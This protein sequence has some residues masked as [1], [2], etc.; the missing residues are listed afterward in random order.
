M[1]S[2]LNSQLFSQKCKSVFF[3]F[4]MHIAHV[5][6]YIGKDFGGPVAGLAAMTAGL[7]SLGRQ[8]EVYAAHRPCEGE[9]VTLAPG[10]KGN[11]CQDV[12]LGILRH[13]ALLWKLL[14]GADC[15]LIHS[16]GLWGDPNRCAA[17]VARRKKIPHLLGTSGMLEPNALRRARWK[18]L[19]VRNL[20]Q[21]RALW[22]AD[23][24]L[25]NSEKEY[26]DIRAY[27]LTNPVALIP[28]PVFGPESVTNPVTTR[29]VRGRL[30]VG[31]RRTL[32]YL[33]RIHPVKGVHR[34]AEAWCR[35]PEFHDCWNLIIAGPD[36]GGFQATIEEILR[37]GGCA[38]SVTFTGSLDD[39]WKW[40]VLRQADLFVMPSDY[41]NFG[42]AIVEALLAG[43]PV[44]ATTRTPWGILRDRQAGW[45]VEP[46]TDALTTVLREALAT[47]GDMLLEMGVRGEAIGGNFAPDVI[48]LQLVEV[49]DWLLGRGDRPGSVRG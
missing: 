14:Q 44:I 46:E 33:G 17:T 32:L 13:S 45:V 35:I 40:G 24:L 7:A 16:H 15:S 6:Q 23:C 41:E 19:I 5:I 9:M 18:K 38:T 3:G 39:R 4:I 29:E 34:L 43:V 10:I 31:R 25:A 21:D 37:K 2:L 30:P 1:L 28:N 20:F 42:I 48:A 49:Y 22:E 11:I 8:V 12:T 26:Q 27:G 36:E 47:D